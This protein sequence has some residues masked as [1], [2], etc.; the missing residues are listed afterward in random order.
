MACVRASCDHQCPGKCADKT[1]AKKYI[2]DYRDRGSMRRWKTFDQKGDAERF[3]T[4]IAPLAQRRTVSTLPTNILM[5]AFA[6]KWMLVV[7]ATVKPSTHLRYQQVLTH[8][9]LPTFGL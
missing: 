8:H 7:E 2:V 4:Q 6:E 3:R 1:H 5:S 9:V